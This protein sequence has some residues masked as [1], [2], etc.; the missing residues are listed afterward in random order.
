MSKAAN[1]LRN[2]EWICLARPNE[3]RTARATH[4]ASKRVPVEDEGKD[5]R[6]VQV[7]VIDAFEAPAQLVVRNLRAT[8]PRTL[9]LID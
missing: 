3:G 1:V 7:F 2:L 6:T 8:Q 5:D 4:H 9:R